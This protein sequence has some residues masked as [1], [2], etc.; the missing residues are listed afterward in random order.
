MII[1]VDNLRNTGII[2]NM[3]CRY[4]SE[5][6]PDGKIQCISCKQFNIPGEKKTTEIANC[7]QLSIVEANK[8]ERI[9]S[10]PWDICFG[11]GL[12]KTSVTL[13]GGEPGAGKSTL[14]LQI[15]NMIIDELSEKTNDSYILYI[16]T[17]EASK[18]IKLRADRLEITEK[19]QKKIY[20]CSTVENSEL[21]IDGILEELNKQPSLIILDS[22]SGLIGEDWA[23]ATE[24]AGTLKKFS[25]L[26]NC[27]TIII[28][29]VNKNIAFAGTMKLQHKVDTT[30]GFIT[31]DDTDERV[32]MTVKNRFGPAKVEVKFIMEE[33]GLNYIDTENEDEEKT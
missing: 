7:I 2:I 21:T 28:D 3:K 29:H 5:P 26:H 9:E 4:C 31:D 14:M 23:W 27:P 19:N 8:H 13:I 16:T 12:V 25:V 11:G 18:E 6:M 10:G 15:A 32:L 20:I 30:I 22:I 33:N 17:E 24:I 1:S